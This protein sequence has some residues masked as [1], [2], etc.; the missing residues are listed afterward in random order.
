MAKNSEQSSNQRERKREREKERERE[1]K[2]NIDVLYIQP[3][4]TLEKSHIMKTSK[5]QDLT[6]R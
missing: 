3:H 2:K 4:Q 5:A 6:L 1:E